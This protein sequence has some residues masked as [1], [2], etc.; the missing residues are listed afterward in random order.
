M[1]A[2]WKVASVEK[3]F[4]SLTI[5]ENVGAIGTWNS[6]RAEIEALAPF[7]V[8]TVEREGIEIFGGRIE[9]P[10]IDFSRAGSEIRP[11]GFDYTIRLTDFLTPQ[12]SI[13]DTAT[14][15]ALAAILINTPFTLIIIDTFSYITDPTIFDTHCEFIDFTFSNTCI[16][17]EKTDEVLVEAID[18]AAACNLPSGPG[19]RAC[20]WDG[21]RHFL[22]FIS[23]GTLWY[24][25]STDCGATWAGVT[26]TTIAAV[27]FSTLWDGSFVYLFVRTALGQTQ[28]WRSA[29]VGAV[30]TFAW[31]DTGAWG[32]ITSG[33]HVDNEGHLWFTVG[34]SIYESVD[35]GATWNIMG[36]AGAN[37]TTH[38]IFQQG[39]Q[40]GDISVIVHNNNL[41]DLE[42]W[43]WDESATNFALVRKIDDLAVVGY[44]SGGQDG[45]YGKHLCWTDGV[46]ALLYNFAAENAAWDTT[47][48]MVPG[49]GFQDFAFQISADGG[50]YAYVTTLTAAGW[51]VRKTSLASPGSWTA[52][53]GPAPGVD[54]VQSPMTFLS[55]G[56]YSTFFIAEALDNDIFYM[57]PDPTGM[58]LTANETTGYFLTNTITATG[59]FV[60][61]GYC[62]A[63]GVQLADTDWSVRLAADGTLLGMGGQQPTFDMDI[64]SGGTV[65]TSIKIRVDFTDTGDDPYVSEISVSE[66]I[67]EV[68]FETDFEDTYTGMK[69]WVRLSGAEFW[70]DK[71]DVLHVAYARGSDKS[72]RIIL[73]NSKT[74]DYPDVEPNIKVVARNPD[75]APYANV[76]YVIGAEGPPR[77]EVEVRDQ[78]GIDEHG[79]HWYCH[80]D[81]DI[82][83]TAMA[84]TVG[85]IELARRSVVI[86]RIRAVILDEYDPKDIEIGDWVWVVAEFGED[87]RTKLNSSMRVVSLNRSWGPSGEQVTLDLINLISASEYW[88]HLT[89]ISDLTRWVTA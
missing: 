69:K 79:E 12:A 5:N 20:F 15:T 56:L 80:R 67:D 41:N 84:Q 14:A 61:W 33:P 58:R 51:R 21:T 53:A 35:G 48:S 89:T 45:D 52:M 39:L 70:L 27:D 24:T 2:A 74:S 78:P 77:I 73:K 26:D 64:A 87:V 16:E 60:K 18:E 28:T 7:S 55:D 36:N 59:A 68:T 44:V 40:V 81:P 82:Q 4:K 11:S 19:Y 46:P 17:F 75:W 6:V 65:E 43:L 10:G 62:A 25:S 23:A 85:A 34:N 37:R 71:N 42:E 29:I 57:L 88:T 1:N 72:D 9:Q 49:A 50:L 32:W 3:T 47:I 30:L 8:I 38:Y 63:T 76:I 83:T 54:R 31:R 13:V 86:D 66:K 22:L